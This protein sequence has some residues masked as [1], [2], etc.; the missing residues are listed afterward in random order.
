MRTTPLASHRMLASY[1]T[2]AAPH[3]ARATPR[4]FNLLPLITPVTPFVALRARTKNSVSAAPRAR[5]PKPGGRRSTPS[6]PAPT[7]RRAADHRSARP[8]D[9]RKDRSGGAGHKTSMA[10]PSHRRGLG[11]AGEDARGSDDVGTPTH[12]A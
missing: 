2:S 3:N 4:A 9:R 5:E 11:S 8:A 7:P 1:T 12:R 6:G 10:G